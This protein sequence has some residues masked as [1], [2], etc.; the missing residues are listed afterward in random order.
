[1]SGLGNL[2]VQD[3]LEGVDPLAVA[4]KNVLRGR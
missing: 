1:M 4:V 3:L 2:A